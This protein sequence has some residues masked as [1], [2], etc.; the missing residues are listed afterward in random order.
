MS[1]GAPSSS[2]PPRTSH[3]SCGSPTWGASRSTRGCRGPE[4]IDR[5]DFA[6]FDLD[7]ADGTRWE[8]VVD[9]ALHIK[10]ALDSLGLRA[11]PKTSGAT[12]LHIYV[13]LDPVHSYG[14]VRRFVET[15]GRLMVA[16]DP[17]N[18]TME[19]DI[20]ARAGKVFIDHNQNVGGKTIA[21]VY[22]VRPFPGAPVSTPL[23]WKEVEEVTPDQFTIATI[24]TRLNEV[25][26]RFAPVLAGGQT[27]DD[28]DLALGLDDME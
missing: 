24:W 6:I 9:A 7:P 17:A 15:V 16:A 10:V 12:G 23:T 8:Q 3:R 18:V 19:W 21:S 5:P 20:P 27:L 1:A 2:A 28:A 14:R 25:G 22:A 13:P 26:D 11:Y 4:R